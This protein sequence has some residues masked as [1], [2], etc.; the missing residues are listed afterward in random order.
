MTHIQIPADQPPLSYLAFTLAARAQ[1][2]TAED[3]L[4]RFLLYVKLQGM[5]LYPAQEEA[6]LEIV[7]GKNV[8]LNTPTGS[9]KSLVAAAMHFQAYGTQQKS[10]YTAPT[11]ALV[12]EKFFT[13]CKDF[14]PANVGLLTG[15]ASVNRDAPLICCTAEIL[16]NM[17]LREGAQVDAGYVVMDEF[18]YYSDRDRGTAWQIPL[19]AL[20]QATFLLMSATLGDPRLF[21]ERLTR[22]NGRPTAVV[23]SSQRP[24]TLDWEY[25]EPPLHETVLDLMKQERVPVYLVSFTQRGC[26]EEAQNLMSYDYCTK[27]HKRAITAALQGVRF[28]TPYGKEVQRFVRHGIGLHHGGLLPK[29]RRL[30]ERLAGPAQNH[31]RHRHP[32]SGCQH[33]H[34]HGAADQTVQ[35]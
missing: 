31:C 21:Q 26:A 15:D 24:V 23:Q 5:E 7:Q 16:A 22:L 11:K 3:L 19:L 18:H 13:L 32:R 8:I 14:G 10:F 4:D 1:D 34:P 25:R 29:Y 12:N 6:I 30:V 20:P 27:D 35:V 2:V 28:D 33:P 9:G 17:A